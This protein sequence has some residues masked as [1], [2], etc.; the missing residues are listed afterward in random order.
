MSR[1]HLLAFAAAL[2]IAM[3]VAAPVAAQLPASGRVLAAGD[4]TPVRDASVTVIG[5]GREVR[6]DS[7]GRYTIAVPRGTSRIVVRAPG[8]VPDTSEVIAATEPVVRSDI[9]LRRVQ[10]L[11]EVRV[12]ERRVPPKMQAFEDRRKS[13]HGS[14]IDRAALEKNA[15]LRTGDIIARLATGAKVH[16]RGARSWAVGGR[17]PGTGSG[18]MKSRANLDR[19]D[20]AAGAP[21]NACY[22]D[23]Y[24]DGTIVYN[25]ANR[26]GQSLWDLNSLQPDAIEGIEV[27]SPARTPAQ[28][29]RTGGGCGVILIWTRVSP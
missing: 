6:T 1:S 25:S 2:I 24:L 21:L 13:Q 14:F 23:V 15:T 12:S 9:V 16:H 18:I 26:D 17:G 29:N 22:M 8:F 10:R 5:D 27:Y 7:L 3:P 28:Y 20:I 19:A 11:E 4:R